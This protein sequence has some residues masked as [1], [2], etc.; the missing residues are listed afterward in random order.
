M[1][2]DSLVIVTSQ[3]CRQ[4]HPLAG[5]NVPAPIYKGASIFTRTTI[6]NYFVESAPQTDVFFVD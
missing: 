6:R 3:L 4:Q 5:P 2:L 1:T